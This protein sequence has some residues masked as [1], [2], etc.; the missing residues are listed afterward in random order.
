[1]GLTL[2]FLRS[3]LH[4]FLKP[5]LATFLSASAWSA[6]KWA[7]IFRPTSTSAISIDKIA[8]AVPESKPLD[9][10]AFEILSGGLMYLFQCSWLLFWIADTGS[11]EFTEPYWSLFIYA[12]KAWD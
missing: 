7:P 10:T 3:K 11:N 6:S 4:I 1:M 8:Y 12:R 5:F 2:V 9:K